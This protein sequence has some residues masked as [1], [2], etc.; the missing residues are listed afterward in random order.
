MAGISYQPSEN[1]SIDFEARYL[2]A[3]DIDMDVEQGRYGGRITADYDVFSL[4]A[5][6]RYRF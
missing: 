2:T 1:W 4:G 5:V 3:S 6:A